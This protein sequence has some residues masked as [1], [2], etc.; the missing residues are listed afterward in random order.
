M[1]LRQA[2]QDLR[3]DGFF[4]PELGRPAKAEEVVEGVLLAAQREHE[5]LKLVHYGYLLA[6]IAYSDFVDLHTAN[7]CVR[8]AQ[9]LSWTQFVLL[10]IVGDEAQVS[11]LPDG[12]ICQSERR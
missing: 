2:G 6:N 11:S 9:E 10:G 8:K 12:F 1:S 5:E 3:S 4:E 7:W